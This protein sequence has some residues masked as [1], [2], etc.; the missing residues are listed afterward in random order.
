ME[1]SA[2]CLETELAS[3]WV[4]FVTFCQTVSGPCCLRRQL[5]HHVPVPKKTWTGVCLNGAR[6]WRPARTWAGLCFLIWL[7]NLSGVQSAGRS[8]QPPPSSAPARKYI[9]VPSWVKRPRVRTAVAAA[10]LAQA[11]WLLQHLQP[12]RCC[13]RRGHV[14]VS[15][16][17]S[18][19]PCHDPQGGGVCTRG[20]CLNWRA[21][22]LT[23]PSTTDSAHWL[24]KK[25]G[26]ADKAPGTGM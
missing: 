19:G 3:V 11:P 1:Q 10:S 24:T 14:C 6:A 18:F 8:T 17:D 15:L 4:S 21:R 12:S 16:V 2:C 9:A 20:Q 7:T 23:A 26:A 22:V 25:V 5:G 13:L